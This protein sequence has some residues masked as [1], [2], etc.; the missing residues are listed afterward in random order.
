M[1]NQTLSRRTFLKG[2]GTAMALPLLDAMMPIGALAK[3]ADAH[4]NRMA[5]IFIPNGAH[6]RDWTPEGDGPA[7]ELPYIL[8]NKLFRMPSAP[9]SKLEKGDESLRGG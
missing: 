5:F 9:A 8:D 4:P 2:V 7:F 6:M 3:A 1:T